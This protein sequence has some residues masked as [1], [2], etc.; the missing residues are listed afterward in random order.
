VEHG[1]EQGLSIGTEP[2]PSVG[3][4]FEIRLTNITAVAVWEEGTWMV[5]LMISSWV[6]PSKGSCVGG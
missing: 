1:S 5:F 4:H 3:R 2:I 6:C